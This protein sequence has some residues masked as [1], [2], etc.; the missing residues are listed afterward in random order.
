M[1]VKTKT[2]Y[3]GAHNISYDTREEAEASFVVSQI[4]EFLREYVGY[5]PYEFEVSYTASAIVKHKE[6]FIQILGQ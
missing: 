1:E 5:D 2:I 3:I 4:V 6:K